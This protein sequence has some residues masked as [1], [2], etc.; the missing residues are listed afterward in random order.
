MKDL[1]NALA[2]IAAIRSQLALAVEFHGYGP[3]TVFHGSPG[4]SGGGVSA[5]RYSGRGT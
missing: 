4:G 3:L 5:V 2:E 1:D